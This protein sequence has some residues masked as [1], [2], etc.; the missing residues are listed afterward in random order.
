MT[1]ALRVL[2][3]GLMTTL[4]DL[5]RPG[6]QRLGIPV[7]GALD[8][9][10]LRAANLIVGNPAAA[11]ALEIAYQGPMLAVEADSVRVALAGAGAMLDILDEAAGA[12]A[13]PAKPPLTSVYG[14]G[15]RTPTHTARTRHP[16]NRCSAPGK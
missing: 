7:S 16:A 2:S 8:P 6:F 14:P 1:A 11:A 10:S 4:Q 5:G 15:K 9:V 3:P 13:R 12:I